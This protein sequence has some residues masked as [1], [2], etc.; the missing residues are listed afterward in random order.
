MLIS[1]IFSARIVN[2]VSQNSL[3]MFSI[4]NLKKSLNT[5]SN[6]ATTASLVKHVALDLVR[7]RL[8]FVS[9]NRNADYTKRDP[10]R[11]CI[12]CV[13]IQNG[14]LLASVDGPSNFDRGGICNWQEGGWTVSKD[15]LL[16]S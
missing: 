3:M 9:G 13:D 15:N 4:R 2:R 1:W 5:S 7:N 14:L 11:W 6:T 10:Y 16:D 8:Y 12:N